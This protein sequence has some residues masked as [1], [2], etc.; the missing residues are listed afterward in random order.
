MTDDAPLRRIHS[1]AAAGRRAKLKVFLG[2]APGVGKTYRMLQ[3]ARDM[4]DQRVDVVVGVAETH[5]RFDTG[6]VLL[7]LELLR[8]RTVEHRGR[9]RAEFDLDAALARRPRVLLVDELAHSN[10]EGSRHPRRWQDVLELLDAGIDVFTTLNVQHLESLNDVVEQITGVR[11]RETVP[12]AVL[13]RAD[14]VELV[15]LPPDEL[16]ARLREGKIYASE[17]AARATE[18]FF[19]RGNLLALR[20]LAL[21]RVAD[22]VDVDVR[23]YREENAIEQ[24]WTAG[25]RVLVCVGPSPASARLLRAARRLAAG[26]RAGWVAVYVEPSTADP[27]S[28][29]DLDRLDAHLRLAGSMG[30]EVARLSGERVS[31][32]ILTYARKRDVTR[33]ILG[34]PTHPRLRDLV[35][36]SLLDEVVRGS[37]GID[38][39]V[40]SGDAAEP[41]PPGGRPAAEPDAAGYLLAALAVAIATGATWLARPLLALPDLSMIYLLVIIVVAVRYGRGPSVAA[42]A[43]SVAAFNFFFVQPLFTFAVWDLHNVL[44]FAMMFGVGQLISAL[45]LRVKRQG[46]NAREREART[47][48]LY[49]LSRA[50]ASTADEGGAARVLAEQGAEVFLAAVG[51]ALAP[52]GGAALALDGRAGDV[53]FGADEQEVIRWVLEHGQPA[54]AGTD[55]LPGARITC[56][57]VRSGAAV[58]GVLALAGGHALDLETRDFLET[59]VRQGALAIERA[60]L[61]EEA[62]AA[63][64]RVRVEEMRSSLLS[65][66]SHDLRTPLAAITGAATTLRDDSATVPAAERAGLLDAICEEADRM[67]RL[68]ANLL[69][70]TRLESGGLRLRREW[71]PL[72]EMVGSALTRLEGRLVGR[73]VTTRLPEGLPLLSVDPLLIEQVL[74]N[75]LENA[76]KYT[77]AGSALEVA[78]RADDARVIIEVADRGPGLSE[79]ARGRVFEKFYRGPHVGIGGVGL[80]LPICKGMVEAHGGTIEVFNREGGGAVFRVVLPRVGDAPSTEPLAEAAR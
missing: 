56:V 34:K 53:P 31:A 33:I 42:S 18:S 50:L 25:E 27:L 44:T 48:S 1:D 19:R 66:V 62:R 77:P 26:L 54:G 9:A 3:V 46:L 7:G 28:R 68:V 71:V 57:P 2:F 29:D 38:V 52:K 37:G 55:T 14:E 45:A 65:A 58:L 10:A 64:L 70:M 39:H 21:R 35:R 73:A 51:V 72:E 69:D 13:D 17:R 47:A 60:L 24:S 30:A 63:A 11:V 59:F 61:A 8:P 74:V 22:R 16:L 76:A 40:I 79:E 49:A 6:A 36:G 43:L 80:G 32:A 41:R 75:L 15:D 4:T 78:A 20:E 5:G 67:E 12:D 23:A